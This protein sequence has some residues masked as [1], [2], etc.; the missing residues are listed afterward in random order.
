M[1]CEECRLFL[2]VIK[3]DDKDLWAHGWP[4]VITHLLI[5]KKYVDIRTSLWSYLSPI[6]RASLA[7]LANKLGLPDATA[8]GCMFED[9]TQDVIR[10]ESLYK[11]GSISDFLLAMNSTSFPCVK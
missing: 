6:H 10:F 2:K 5:N 4:S 7:A 8:Q 11:S 3:S 1:L 9:Y